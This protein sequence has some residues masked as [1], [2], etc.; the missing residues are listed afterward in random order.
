MKTLI[1]QSSSL[2]PIVKASVLIFSAG[3]MEWS[4]V[5]AEPAAQA[6]EADAKK[7]VLEKSDEKSS[8]DYRNWFTVSSGFQFVTGDKAQFQ[9]RQGVPKGAFGGVEDIHYEQDI[10]KKGLLQFDGRGIFDNHDYSMK[11]DLSHP[12]IGYLRAGYREFRTWYDG[13]GG[14]FPKNRQWFSLYDED[15]ALDRGEAFF[16]GGLTL[17]DRP[18]L[19]FKYSHLFR[20]R[21]KDST[22]WGDSNLT[23]VTVAN[24]GRGIVP[25]FLDIDERRDIFESDIKHTFGNT[26][27]GLGLRYEISNNDNSRNIHR[28]P[29]E[30]ALDRYITQREGVVADMFNVHA[31]SETRFNEKVLFTTGYSFTTLDT[32]ISGSRIYGGGYEAVY[33]PLFARRQQRDE[34]FLALSGGS[35]VK[36]YVMNINLMLTPWDHL[37]LVP[38]LRVEKQNQE[39]VASFTETDFGASPT[40]AAIQ[41]ELLNTRERGFLDVSESLEARY[42]GLTNWVFY[43]RGEWLEGDG[44]LKE[45]ETEATT[46]TLD[47]FRDTDSTRFTQKYIAGANWYPLKRLNFSG[48]YYHKIRA[49][50]YDHRADF[51]ATNAPPSANRYPAF[52]TDHDFE[53]DDVNFRVTWRLLNNLTLVS[54]YDFQLSTVRTTGD[55]LSETKSAEMTS[56]IF[57]ESVTWSPLSRLYLQGS[58]NYVLD[59][60]DTPADGMT[61]STNLVL[62]SKNNYWNTSFLTGYALTDKTDLQA[63][64]SYYR[65]NNYEDNSQFSQPYGAGAEEHGVTASLIRRIRANLLWTLKYGFFS[66]RDVTSGGNNNYDAHLV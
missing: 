26:D 52:L 16:E 56:H 63:Q 21:K 29:G 64:Y 14:F 42:T 34:G 27:L 4:L 62:N 37:T 33:D 45:W 7:P 13:S 2:Q 15:F 20:D 51:P 28:R 46:G 1:F 36:Q 8:V 61:G 12:D 17:P 65:A 49:N 31:F 5:A 41:D 57:S 32:D 43:T 11:L 53:T 30:P 40:F 47:L 24:P 18:E 23:G 35:Q 22:S 38:A 50:D 10:G 25:T 39:G 6:K 66:N 59:R 9:H 58:I 54:R 60:T 3:L 55:F 48:Q 44:N 19:S